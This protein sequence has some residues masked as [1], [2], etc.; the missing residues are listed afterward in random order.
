[1]NLAKLKRKIWFRLAMRGSGQ[2]DPNKQLNRL[3]FIRDPWAIDTP[4]E[5]KRI[6][7]TNDAIQKAF[8]RIDT[9]LEVGAGEGVQSQHLAKLCN[10]LTGIDVS[11]RAIARARK[12]AARHF[13]GATFNTGDLT[14]QSWADEQGKFDVVIA[15]EVLNYMSDPKAFLDRIARLSK[16]GWFLTYYAMN[17]AKLGPLVRGLPG[18]Q[19]GE[20]LYGDN[21][22]KKSVSAWY[23]KP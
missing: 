19:T 5:L 3:Y 11:P 6:Q 20:V 1:M 7:A 12:R 23:T 15:A 10:H 16:R 17:E 18:V 8:G 13:P 2:N 22:E 4:G 14:A 21:N 9:M